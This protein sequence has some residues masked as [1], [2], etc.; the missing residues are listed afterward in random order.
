MST[1]TNVTIEY[2]TIENFVAPQSEGVV[3]Q[4]SAANWT[5]QDDT[6]ENNPDGAGAMLG[7]NNVLTHD[8]LTKNGQYGFQSYSTA[9]P[10]NVTVT[11]NEISYNDTKNY[12]ATTTGCGCTG[13]AKFWETTGAT[14]TGNYVHD[15]ESVGIWADTDN[16][17][18][19]ISDNY[20]ADNY[21]EG[22]IYEIS[23]NA[24]IDDNTFVGNAVGVGPDQSGVPGAGRLHQRVGFR[25]PGGRAVRHRRSTSPATSSRTTGPA[26]SC[27]RTPTGTA[28]RRPTR[29]PA[30]ARS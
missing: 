16:S 7:T 13:G 14:I 3:N 20:F 29:R 18:F 9:G 12:T 22:I 27:G 1:A 30:R 10:H 25:P 6:I 5:I 19:D 15:N 4:N 26:S 11:D 23:Y 2:L 28:G 8:C 21:A 17:G 24:Q